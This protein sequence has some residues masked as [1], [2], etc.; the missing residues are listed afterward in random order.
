M[1][2]VTPLEPGLPLFLVRL[3]GGAQYAVLSGA[4]ASRAQAAHA[5]AA[6]AVYRAVR[7]GDVE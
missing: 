4:Y 1:E 5:A 7:F 3:H 6:S 2:D